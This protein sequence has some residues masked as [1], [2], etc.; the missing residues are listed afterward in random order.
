[1]RL[2]IDGITAMSRGISAGKQNEKKKIANKNKNGRVCLF[3]QNKT[4]IY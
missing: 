3:S 1:M 2:R 4:V